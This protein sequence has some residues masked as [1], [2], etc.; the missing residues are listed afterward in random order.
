MEAVAHFMDPV[1]VAVGT[2]TDEVKRG[3]SD[4]FLGDFF[5]HEGEGLTLD[6]LV[7]EPV[8]LPCEL[9]LPN[10]QH[11]VETHWETREEGKKGG[12]ARARA[13]EWMYMYMP[14]AC[15]WIRVHV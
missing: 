6:L 9:P 7:G 8:E 15:I 2:V 11:L 13:S 10:L 14:S 3:Q 4:I 5:Y 1:I 12:R